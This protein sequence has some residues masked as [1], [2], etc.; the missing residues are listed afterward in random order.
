VTPGRHPLAEAPRVCRYNAP[1]GAGV[2]VV[3]EAGVLRPAGAGSVAEA[4]RLGLR[5]GLQLGAPVAGAT[6]LAPIDAQE[7][8]AAGVTYRRSRDA[9]MEEA[10]SETRDLYAD[11]YESERGEIFF[12]AT[13][14][15]VVG[16]DAPIVMRR[17]ASS[18][19]PEPEVALWLDADLRV[20]GIGLANDVT[21]RDLEAEN[22]LYLPQAK[23]WQGSC[24]LG[25]WV[26]AC[27]EHG[28]ASGVEVSLDIRRNG[29]S[30]LTG[31]VGLDELRRSPAALIELLGRDNTFPEGAILLTGTGIVPPDDVSLEEGDHVH[32]AGTH[33]GEL[34]NRVEVGVAKA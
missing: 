34:R 31:S 15:R 30:I 1:S 13:P 7:V 26:V 29:S 2:G 18:T 4:L 11:V 22:P 16:P 8:W 24:A 6:L 10:G 32:I 3:D 25:P 27:D 33:L 28:L 12:K 9:R 21:A 20:L 14:H 17:D 23:I 5:A 19:V